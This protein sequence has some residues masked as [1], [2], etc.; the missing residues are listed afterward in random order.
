MKEIDKKIL[1]EL[2]E[3]SEISMK[4]LGKKVNLSPS[5]CWLRIKNLKDQGY[6]SKTVAILNVKKLNLEKPIFVQIKTTKHNK[7]WTDKFSAV[8]KKTPEIIECHRLMG[9]TDYLLKVVVKDSESY[10]NFYSKLT[11]EIDLSNVSGLQ[12][13]EEVKQTSSLPLDYI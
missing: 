3:N 9:D 2:Q 8:V 5:P 11:K 12:S 13:L 6:I 4:E 10:N 1:S 7:E